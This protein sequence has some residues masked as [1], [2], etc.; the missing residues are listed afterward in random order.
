VNKILYKLLYKG[1]LLAKPRSSVFIVGVQKQLQ[2]IV[3]NVRLSNNF[4]LDLLDIL[5][6]LL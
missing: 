4:I 5:K 3:L 6:L 1:D 2:S